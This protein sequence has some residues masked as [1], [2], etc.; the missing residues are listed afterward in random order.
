MA[1]LPLR[2]LWKCPDCYDILDESDD[3]HKCNSCGF[4]FEFLLKPKKGLSSTEELARYDH[5]L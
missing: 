5:G 3:Y 1:R 2:I 4:E